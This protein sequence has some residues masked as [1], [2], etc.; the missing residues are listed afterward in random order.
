MIYGNWNRSSQMKGT[1]SVPGIG[2]KRVLNK[3]FKIL[4]F[5]EFRTS[6]MNNETQDKCI[7][8]KI[9]NKQGK[10]KTLHSVLVSSILQTEKDVKEMIT[11]KRY[12]NRNRHAVINFKIIVD[13]YEKEGKRPYLFDRSNKIE[14][15]NNF[16]INTEI[17][18]VID[19]NTKTNVLI[20][21]VD[22]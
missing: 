10:T 2:I 1:I 22:D 4:N 14:E 18:H 16:K 11:R 9:I 3:E 5:D 8:A 19:T 17:I 21:C 15:I 12:Q 13:N 6:C 7:N 20:M